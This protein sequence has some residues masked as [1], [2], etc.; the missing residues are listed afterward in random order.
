MLEEIRDQPAALDRTLRGQFA[1]AERLRK[2]FAV[3]RP[4]L[5]ILAARGTSDNAAQSD[6]ICSRLPLASRSPSLRRR[7]SLC[8]VPGSIFVIPS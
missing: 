5:I 1:D 7:Y 6:V 8:I 2:L 3:N 4:R